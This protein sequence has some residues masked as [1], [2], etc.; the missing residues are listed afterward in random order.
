MDEKAHIFTMVR[1]KHD[2]DA[3]LSPLAVGQKPNPKPLYVD[4]LF[5][6]ETNKPFILDHEGLYYF[7]KD[8]TDRTGFSILGVDDRF[9]KYTKPTQLTKPLVYLTT[10][11]EYSS[12]NS[13]A[14]SKK[15]LDQFL[16]IT[17]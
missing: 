10:N 8:T 4:S 12:L 7:I 2:F 16:A 11:Q 9:P 17:L 1:Y 6:V 15:N 14:D 13:T 3:A 5:Q